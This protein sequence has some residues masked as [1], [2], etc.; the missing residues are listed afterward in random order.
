MGSVEFG[1][2]KSFFEH[3]RGMSEYSVFVETGTYL[4]D[5]ARWAS[6]HFSRVYTIEISWNLHNQAKR[7][8]SDLENVTPLFGDSRILLRQLLPDLK[9]EKCVFWLD[10][11]WSGGETYGRF[12]ECPLL[13]ELQ[14]V[15]Q[16]GSGN[17][18]LVD[19]AR[20]FLT[21][22][23]PPHDPAAW[24]ELSDI[25]SALQAVPR[26]VGVFEDVVYG[27]PLQMKDSFR[28]YSVNKTLFGSGY[29]SSAGLSG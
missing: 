20:Y 6:R 21:P 9:G 17:I 2:P 8:L 4:G 29:G 28:E 1:L 7:A 22:P 26:Y 24:P 25:V 15:N 27:L 14:V 16:Y 10:G 18:V 3:C 23:P 5:S 11:H 12:D 13:E 19:D